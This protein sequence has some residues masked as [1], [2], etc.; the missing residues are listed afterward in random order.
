MSGRLLS[1]EFTE[2]L[3]ATCQNCSKCPLGNTRINSVV[4]RG[5][6]TPDILWVGE[7]PGEKEEEQGLPFVGTTGKLLQ[8][9]VDAA[10][11]TEVSGFANIQKC[12]PP[13]NR[14]PTVIEKEACRPYLIQQI[15]FYKP[16]IIV[17]VG[18]HSFGAL[19]QDTPLG[20]LIAK[21]VKITK[22]HG[23]IYWYNLHVKPFGQIPVFLH[24]HPSYVLR[25][26]N[27][28]KNKDIYEIWWQDFLKI[29]EKYDELA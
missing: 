4:Y 12:R 11:L 26:A 15:E 1:L 8:K 24:L 25:Q 3:K 10:G 9:G 20:V 5:S 14:D 18:R 21:S 2:T 28:D 16:K 27:I 22:D 17:A 23:N 19:L 7:A 13:G 29:K 6:L